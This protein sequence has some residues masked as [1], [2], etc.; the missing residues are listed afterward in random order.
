MSTNKSVREANSLWQ[1]VDSRDVGGIESHLATLVPALAR[2][3]V[4]VQLVMLA[5]YGDSPAYMFF[6]ERGIQPLVLSGGLLSLWRALRTYQ[7]ALLHTHG[8][9][10]GILG[11]ICAFLNGTPTV[12]TFHAGEP[13][14]GI[15]RWYDRLDRWTS[16]LASRRIAV[17]AEI[18]ARLPSPAMQLN[19]FVSLPDV[20]R[21]V[22]NPRYQVAFVGR[23]SEEKGPDLFVDLARN[24]PDCQ[25]HMFGPGDSQRY[26]QGAPSNITHHGLVNMAEMWPHIG[27]LVMSSRYEGLPMAALEAMSYGV[28]V[29]AYPVGE[30]PA[31]VSNGLNGQIAKAKDTAAL[32]D[33]LGWYLDL[34]EKARQAAGTA[35]RR[36]ISAEYSVDAVLPTLL[37]EYRAINAQI[38]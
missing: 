38:S 2:R 7:P 37:A 13:G 4:Q 14:A 20:Q 23:M 30:L 6:T 33:A 5:D 21:G 36:T 32:A 8:Y 1:L 22:H 19:N 18:A 27:V 3:G 17:S 34:D 24:F 31:L 11:R 25:F 35:A 10:A 15:V 29:V 9:K 12:S 26:L 16:I 28:P